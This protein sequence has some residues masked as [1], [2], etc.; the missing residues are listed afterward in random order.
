MG[1]G[2]GL[3]GV[4][5]VAV[6]MVLARPSASEPSPQ[7][8]G[9]ADFC[10]GR[11]YGFYADVPAGCRSYYICNPQL[12][13]GKTVTRQFHYDCSPGKVFD[14]LHLTCVSAA[15]AAEGCALA[16]GHYGLN[17]AFTLRT[18][19]LASRTTSNSFSCDGRADGSYAD[20]RSGCGS[21]FVCS[22]I[23]LAQSPQKPQAIG[24]R[25]SCPLPTV[26]DQ[27]SGACTYP[28]LAVPCEHSEKL[29]KPRIEPDT[30]QGERSTPVNLSPRGDLP[31]LNMP[32]DSVFA[33][34]VGN[35]LL[36]SEVVLAGLGLE[37]TMAFHAVTA[38]NGEPVA[39]PPSSNFSCDG[40]MYGYYA[41]VELQCRYFHVCTVKAGVDGKRV[42]ERHSF[43]CPDEDTYF[44]Q[45]EYECVWRDK[46]AP[47][48]EAAEHYDDNTRWNL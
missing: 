3:L 15:K 31:L 23:Q 34:Q 8:T 4:V 18:A 24:F 29:Y 38:S 43:V 46:A 35:K 22:R 16:E 33:S 20:V 26:F 2:T 39:Y 6:V 1:G 37:R 36:S 40:R 28:D 21:Y 11:P 48:S 47:C 44:A 13:F 19:M 17:E 27:Q 5:M 32:E 25:L 42:Y 45:L 41:D 10:V 14:Q 7:G 30:V 12:I 9:R